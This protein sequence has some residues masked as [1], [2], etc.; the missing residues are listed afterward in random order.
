M[1]DPT[2]LVCHEAA[3][4][5][6]AAN[7]AFCFTLGPSPK[8]LCSLPSLPSLLS[9]AL[10]DDLSA[11]ARMSSAIN[12]FLGRP[13]RS[14]GAAISGRA[15]GLLQRTGAGRVR[16]ALPHAMP[17][18]PHLRREAAYRALP[19]DHGPHAAHL[20]M[21]TRHARCTHAG[22]TQPL[23]EPSL[24][25]FMAGCRINGCSEP[26]VKRWSRFRAGRAT[27][28]LVH[29]ALQVGCVCRSGT[30]GSHRW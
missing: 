6:S 7:V 16:G 30:R 17:T 28:G 14:A 15:R 11:V 13:L 29:A 18:V 20:K 4:L 10:L 21:L 2:V 5:L 25:A 1:P 24:K 19:L 22:R 9:V 12:F 27:F 3:V 8:A 23:A 26:R